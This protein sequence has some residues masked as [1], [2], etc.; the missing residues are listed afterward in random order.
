MKVEFQ[1]KETKIQ[2][3][4]TDPYTTLEMSIVVP[5]YNEEKNIEEALRRIQA[6]QSLKKEPW[7]CLIVNDGSTDRT[8]AITRAAIAAQPESHFKLL[9]NPSNHGKGF[10]VRQGVLAVSGRFILVTDAD[11]SAPIKELDKLTKAL[12]EG[13][14]IAIGSRALKSPGGDVQQSFKRWLAGRIFNGVVRTLALRGIS[15]TQ[16]G[17]KCFKKQAAHELF[18]AQKL[19]GFSFDVEVLRLAQKRGLRIKEVPVMWR[20]ARDSRVRLFHDSLKMV[21]DLFYL[22][23]TA[24]V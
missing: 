18:R 15:D 19:D 21:R 12:N 4:K 20:Q 1:S 7:E 9:S 3:S 22:R 11:L 5:V 10:A 13:Y 24:C 6:F 2:L 23:R 14:D 17:F 8:E 16:C